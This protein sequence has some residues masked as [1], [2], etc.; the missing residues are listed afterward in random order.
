MKKIE[1]K[2]LYQLLKEVQLTTPDLEDMHPLDVY[3]L[4]EWDHSVIFWEDDSLRNEHVPMRE[5]YFDMKEMLV[6]FN[7]YL[8]RLSFSQAYIAPLYNGR[9]IG[10][11]Y[12]EHYAF[13][14][15]EITAWL[16]LHGMRINSAACLSVDRQE[17]LEIT[18]MLS[19]AGFLGMSRLHVFIPEAKVV[20][21]PHHH[22]NYL[23]YTHQK[24]VQKSLLQEV[25][26]SLDLVRLFERE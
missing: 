17:L 16:H 13:I 21:E 10:H 19:E 3:H 12:D 14:V 26:A 6:F 23:I 22:M 25:T 20:I 4:H 5:F 1:R 2:V 11:P 9:F 18:A 24:E 15:K 8:Q 7:G